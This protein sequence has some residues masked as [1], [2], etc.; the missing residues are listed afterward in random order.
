MAVMGVDLS[1]RNLCAV[2]LGWNEHLVDWRYVEFNG[3]NALERARNASKAL[4]DIPWGDSLIIGFERPAGRGTRAVMDMWRIMGIALAL[5][6]QYMQPLIPEDTPIWE[7]TPTEW[8]KQCGI[9]GNSN[10][11]AIHA[12]AESHFR[13]QSGDRYTW[14]ERFPQA[15]QDVSDAYCIAL[16]V[17]KINEKGQ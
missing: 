3:S 8:K 12:H 16:A 6:D 17:L 4:R 15:T 2:T 13:V 7:L 14:Q 1:T 10:K 5:E 11:E 9:P